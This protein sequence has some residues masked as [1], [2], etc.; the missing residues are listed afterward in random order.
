[1]ERRRFVSHAEAKRMLRRAGYTE[2]QIKDVLRDIADPIDTERD[3][4]EL[5]KRGISAGEMMDRMG[6]SP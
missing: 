1:M 6:A 3:G 2:R 5:L 4:D